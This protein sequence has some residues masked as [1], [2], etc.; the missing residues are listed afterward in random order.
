[1]SPIQSTRSVV[2]L[3]LVGLAFAGLGQSHAVEIYVSVDGNAHA[4]GSVASMTDT[5]YLVTVNRDGDGIVT[6]V[7][8]T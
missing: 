5:N 3:F 2:C 1:M 8:V 6:G 7:T 4:D